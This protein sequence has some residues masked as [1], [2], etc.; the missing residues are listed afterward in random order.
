MVE[1]LKCSL[2]VQN[3]AAETE[4][5]VLIKMPHKSVYDGYVFW[6]PSK[7][8]RSAGGK[9]YFYSFSFTKEFE[10]KL[11]KYG[12]GKYNSHDVIEEKTV[13]AENIFNAFHD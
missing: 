1:W 2:N 10:F 3:I 7:L 12:K 8:V 9:G 13:S 11:K 5:A 6:H 4:K